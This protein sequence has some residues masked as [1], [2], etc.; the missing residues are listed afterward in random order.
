MSSPTRSKEESTAQV[1]AY[2]STLAQWSTTDGGSTTRYFCDL[3]RAQWS[4]PPSDRDAEH[5]GGGA[6]QLD[7]EGGEEL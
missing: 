7:F 6:H 1:L 2:A 4:S 5:K 3:A